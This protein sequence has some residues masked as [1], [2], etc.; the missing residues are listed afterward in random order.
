MFLSISTCP[1]LV[2]RAFPP[3]PL[4]ASPPF[5]PGSRSR[6]PYFLRRRARQALAIAQGRALHQVG[7]SKP[8]LITPIYLAAMFC[9]GRSDS[10]LILHHPS[11]PLSGYPPCPTLPC[12]QNMRNFSRPSIPSPPRQSTS[13]RVRP[14]LSS[15]CTFSLAAPTL[16]STSVFLTRPI[17]AAAWRGTRVLLLLPR[18]RKSRSNRTVEG[19]FAAPQL[20]RAAI[21][22]PAALLLK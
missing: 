20:P 6:P 1:W 4:L 16:S 21:T 10:T 9:G 15:P 2:P 5:P 13:V 11:H 22:S 18:V 7:F 8:W 12:A 19:R 17:L 3:T 14:C